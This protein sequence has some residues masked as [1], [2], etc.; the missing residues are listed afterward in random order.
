VR[1]VHHGTG[2]SGQAPRGAVFDVETIG[3]VA[4]PVTCDRTRPVTVGD[5][6]TLTGRRVQR[7]RSNTEVRP[8][9]ATATSEAHCSR[10]SCSDQTHIVT[11]T[12]ASGQ[13][14]LHYVIR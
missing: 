13:H 4:R 3:R 7:V 1:P 2:A 5:L 12:G 9:M 8:V 6:W 10:L 14:I 11:L